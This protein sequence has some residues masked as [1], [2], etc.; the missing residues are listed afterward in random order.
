MSC[1]AAERAQATDEKTYILAGGSGN[2]PAHDPD[3]EEQLQ[4][5]AAGEVK[6]QSPRGPST[7]KALK[8][9]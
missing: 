9:L 8:Y 2:Q 7:P 1:W 6:L 5:P 3:E 4:N